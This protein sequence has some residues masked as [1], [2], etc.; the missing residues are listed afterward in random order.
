M[1]GTFQLQL[2]VTYRKGPLNENVNYQLFIV[3]VSEGVFTIEDNRSV[4]QIGVM[5]SQ[6][7]LSAQSNPFVDMKS[8]KS[9]TYFGGDFFSSIGDFFS[10]SYEGVKKAVPVVKDVIGTAKD[11]AKIASMGAGRK[12]G[13]LVGGKKMSRADLYN[14]LRGGED[15]E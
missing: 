15:D 13:V 7:V 3:T 12:G 14:R 6:D 4:A 8:V 10:K 1:L 2:D 5:T 11:I 9:S